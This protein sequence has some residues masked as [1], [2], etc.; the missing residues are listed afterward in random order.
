MGYSGSVWSF[1]DECIDDWYEVRNNVFH[2]GKQM[3]STPLL[4]TRRQQI[5]D[6]T[7]LV[8]VEILQRQGEERRKEIATRMGSY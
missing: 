6:F 8:L 4:S 5:R 7:S 1:L 2:E 3:Q